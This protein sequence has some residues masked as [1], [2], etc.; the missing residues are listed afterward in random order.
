MTVRRD[1]VPPSGPPNGIKLQVTLDHGSIAPRGTLAATVALPPGTARAGDSV[2]VNY[3]GE[4]P[5][6]IFL[7]GC[8]VSEHDVL[9]ITLGNLSVSPQDPDPITYDVL[10]RRV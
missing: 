4:L 1:R 2:N 9:E 8:R 10:I 3:V 7:G 6:R 5:D